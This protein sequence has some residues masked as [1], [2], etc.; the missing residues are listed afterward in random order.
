MDYDIED[1]NVFISSDGTHS[2]LKAYGNS[3]AK[4]NSHKLD[5]IVRHFIWSAS[6]PKAKKEGRH[7]WSWEESNSIA[8]HFEYLDEIFQN[9]KCQSGLSFQYFLDQFAVR[10]HD[11]EELI[12]LPSLFCEIRWIH[13]AGQMKWVL[14]YGRLYYRYEL[15][16][17]EIQLELGK[18]L[19]VIRE[20]VWLILFL[21]KSM[22]LMTPSNKPTLHLV[23]SIREA[24]SDV[25]RSSFFELFSYH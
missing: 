15:A 3:R 20:T 10:N 12:W 22:N 4:C 14:K 13:I 5:N 8:K 16:K 2:N 11:Y 17:N 9:V 19:T 1:R 23:L 6:Y 24:L 7:G 21:E 25:F 18:H